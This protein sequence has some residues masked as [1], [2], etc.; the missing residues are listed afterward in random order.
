MT[1]K[2]QP[3][4]LFV[5]TVHSPFVE[6]DLS[7]LA[8]HFPVVP[9]IGSGILQILKIFIDIMQAELIVCWFAS[10][11]SAFAVLLGKRL[12][13]KSII[14]I[15]GADL[16]AEKDLGYG[17]WLSK[18][19]SAFVKRA[20][21]KADVVLTVDESLRE[22]AKLRAEYSGNNIHYLPTGYDSQIWKPTGEKKN[23][24][25]T[26]AAASDK[27]RFGIKGI[28]FL[29]TVA[30]RMPAIDFIVIGVDPEFAYRSR[31][32]L[33]IKFYAALPHDQLLRYYQESKVYCQPSRR[34]GLS[35]ALC[36]AMLCGCIPVATN[37]GGNPTAIGDTGFLV[38]YN[39]VDSLVKALKQALDADIE[40]SAKARA[41]IVALFPKEKRERE[42]LK[43]IEQLSE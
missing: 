33:N 7:F 41:R 4:I 9:R 18:W 14:I 27:A 24:V 12:G 37:V 32:S 6:N 28:D 25:L 23:T 19:K 40:L 17:L 39:D 20:L 3:T 8:K 21:R 43:I 5:S 22:E 15:G 38:P 16:A 13:V 26:V 36:E 2:K 11:Y 10:V 1:L 30:Q 29:I 34:E 35:N 31:P 42:L